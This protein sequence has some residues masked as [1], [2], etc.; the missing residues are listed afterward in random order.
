MAHVLCESNVLEQVGNLEQIIK[1]I[2]DG[3]IL[4]DTFMDKYVE[5]NYGLKKDTGMSMLSIYIT[6]WEDRKAMRIKYHF[7]L[8]VD[9]M[10]RV[11]CCFITRAYQQMIHIVFY[12]YQ[13]VTE[14]ERVIRY[15]YP[16]QYE[17]G[18]AMGWFSVSDI[19]EL[20]DTYNQMYPYLDWNI[21]LGDDVMISY[22][23]VKQIKISQ[24]VY[25]QQME[26]IF[27]NALC[28]KNMGKVQQIF[29]EFHKYFI[30]DKVY[31]PKNIKECYMKFFLY[32]ISISQTLGVLPRSFSLQNI[33][34][35]IIQSR[36]SWEIKQIEDSILEKISF[37]ADSKSSNRVIRQMLSII[38]DTYCE[39]I[40]LNE[41]A[42]KLNMTPE[43][44]GT[45][46]YKEMGV[47]FST[48]MKR[49]RVEK[50]K[51]MLLNTQL[52]LYEIAEKTGFSNAKYFSRVF[53]EVTGKLPAE[54]R[55]Y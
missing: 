6:P 16:L 10:K 30:S 46:F 13:D 12:D 54:Y 31:S 11:K 24:C 32:V 21:S 35:K 42:I 27:Q 1:G 45:L 25:P 8:M 15:K 40:T 39:G 4:L 41:I 36:T 44:I 49:C 23:K 38:H 7:Q 19:H 34:E 48:Y 20:K 43:Y 50:A 47:H 37:E 53:R 2:L 55:R 22:P 52:K 26:K 33:L 5:E 29:M 17:G 3:D 51:E 18:I 28:S 14:L 9:M